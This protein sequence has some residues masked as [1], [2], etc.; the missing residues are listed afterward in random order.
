MFLKF[1][2]EASHG[3]VAL[4]VVE[5]VVDPKQHYSRHL[6]EKTDAS[7]N[8]KSFSNALCPCWFI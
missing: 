1:L 5:V 6:S 7:F 8:L 3:Q 4:K 2:Q